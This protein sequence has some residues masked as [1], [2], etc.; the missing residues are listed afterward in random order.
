MAGGQAM[1][2]PAG[3]PRVFRMIRGHRVFTVAVL[4]AVA[5]LLVLP[6]LVLA[7]FFPPLRGWVLAA[8]ALMLVVC[9][10]YVRQMF[11]TIT[12]TGEAL[13]YRPGGTISRWWTQPRV[14]PW[15]AYAFTVYRAQPREYRITLWRGLWLPVYLT[16]PGAPIRT[17]QFYTDSFHGMYAVLGIRP[18]A[19]A[20]GQAWIGVPQCIE[21]ADTLLRTVVASGRMLT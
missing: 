7:A 8:V 14:F 20:G 10:C 4:A 17:L 12:V 9:E 19:G 2:G 15:R 21:S 11:S 3:A 5:L 16:N 1:T 18:R 6:A 13:I